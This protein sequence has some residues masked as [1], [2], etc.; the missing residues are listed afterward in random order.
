MPRD[1][2][3]RDLG[4]LPPRHDDAEFEPFMPQA[5]HILR[6]RT[7]RYAYPA[8]YDLRPVRWPDCPLCQPE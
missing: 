1:Q 7:N 5:E 2:A 4:R 3:R 8:P 6:H